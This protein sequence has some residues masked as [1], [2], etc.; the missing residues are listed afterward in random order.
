V[1]VRDRLR[2][3]TERV[4]V[5]SDGAQSDGQSYGAMISA[6]GRSVSFWSWA[7]KL[8]PGNPGDVFVHDRVSGSTTPLVCVAPRA[9]TNM[10]LPSIRRSERGDSFTCL[11]GTWAGSPSFSFSWSHDDHMLTWHP[12]ASYRLAADDLGHVFRCRVTAHNT[13]GDGIADSRAVSATPLPLRT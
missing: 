13:G 7:P 4:S 10:V 2:G 11:P 9:P 12:S 3:T 6:D 5:R 8:C 1:F